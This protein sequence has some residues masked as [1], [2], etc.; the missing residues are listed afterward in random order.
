MVVGVNDADYDPTVHHILS[1]A[2]CTTNCLAPVVRVLLDSFGI[3]RGF[4]TTVHAY[5]NDQRIL[6]LPHKDLRRARAAALNIIPTSTGAARA[7]AS[8]I[9]ETEGKLDGFAL[10]VPVPDGSMVD[11]VVTLERAATVEEINAAMRA[12]ADGPLAGVL[13]YSEAP[14]VSRDIVGNPHSC[15]FDSMLTMASGRQAKI[16]AWYDNEWGFANRM[17]DLSERLVFRDPTRGHQKA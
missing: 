7:I 10:R 13:E 16:V 6:D 2:S 3:E 9:P 12:A 1:G 14:L 8:V 11:F 5:T 4:M 15:V 17:V